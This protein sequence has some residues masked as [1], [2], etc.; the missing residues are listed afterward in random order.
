MSNDVKPSSR[1][2]PRTVITARSPELEARCKYQSAEVRRML[3]IDPRP[4][5]K[6]GWF[7]DLLDM[8]AQCVPYVLG[9][10]FLMWI[11]GPRLT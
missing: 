4:E 8:I 10:L 11:C 6:Q 5:Y 3:G 9:I 7:G 1:A 2:T